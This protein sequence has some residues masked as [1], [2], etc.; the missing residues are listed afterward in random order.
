MLVTRIFALFFLLL[1]ITGCENATEDLSK[2]ENVELR[3]KWRECAYIQAPSN[4]EQKA[5]SHYERECTLRK[6]EGNLAC[7]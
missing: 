1:T 3:K 2:L 5:C 4:S 7:Y 6:D